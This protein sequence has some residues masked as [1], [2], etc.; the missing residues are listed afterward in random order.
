[1]RRLW[2][3][4][5]LTVVLAVPCASAQRHGGSIGGGGHMGSFSRGAPMMSHGS[6]AGAPRS[7]GVTF[8]SH[9]NPYHFGHGGDGHHHH[10]YGYGYGGYGY[11]GYGY[12]YGYGYPNYGYAYGY[13]PLLWDSGPSYDSS[14]QD[15]YAD[16]NEQ[17]SQQVNE[18]SN[19]VA[20]LRDEQEIRAYT[21]LPTNRQAPPDSAKAN[22]SD[23]TV[24]VF[25]D[26][27]REEISNY[28]VVGRT[29]W[30]FNE[31]RARKI[32]L[33]DLDVPATIKVN[34]DRGVDFNIPR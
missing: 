1:M 19:E 21:P 27:H 7:S 16:Q 2:S 18:L 29:V 26:Q 11:G 15:A 31:A 30:V 33:A 4:A 24:L 20:R 32:P 28:A 5:A 23:P 34:D 22:I 10:H 13:D 9:G 12:G 14:N 25:R 8:T 3:I 6:F 17:L